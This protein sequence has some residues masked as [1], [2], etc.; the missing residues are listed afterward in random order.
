MAYAN[1]NKEGMEIDGFDSIIIVK[2]LADIPCGVTLDVTSVTDNVIKA[3][4]VLVQNTTTKVVKPLGITSG[5]YDSKDAGEEYYGILK[6]SVL[7]SCPMAAVLRI[8]TVNAA[9]A[10]KFVGAE[11]TSTIKA[12]LPHIDFIY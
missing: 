9:A 12:G 6:A 3:G 2:D 10:A 1:L 8:G 5:S 7:K 4:H 11:I